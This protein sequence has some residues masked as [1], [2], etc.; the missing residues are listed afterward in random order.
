M[1]LTGRRFLSWFLLIADY[2][3]VYALSDRMQKEW[4]VLDSFDMLS[5]AY[6]F[7]QTLSRVRSWF[8][9]AGLSQVE[10]NYGYN[11]IEGHG[12]KP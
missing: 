7:P 8:E 5:P 4:A 10:V 2:R 11:G 9:K 3:G 6:D 1:R 12:F